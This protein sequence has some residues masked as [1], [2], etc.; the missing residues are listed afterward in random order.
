VKTL[1]FAEENSSDEV[2]EEVLNDSIYRNFLNAVSVG[3][4]VSDKEGQVKFFNK[5]WLL[6]TGRTLEN[7][8][9]HKWRGEEIHPDDRHSCL[10]TYKTKFKTVSAFEHEYR[11]LRHDAEF[12]CIREYVKP[13]FGKDNTHTG[14]VGTCIDI[15]DIR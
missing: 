3:I 8:L 5:S 12:R 14:F 10:N 4:W 11:L 1:L 9:S 2:S 6:Y 7:E 15:T 13:S